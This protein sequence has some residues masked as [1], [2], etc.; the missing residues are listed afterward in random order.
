MQSRK[1]CSAL[2][3]KETLTHA[4]T[5]MNFED[6]MLREISQSQK[7]KYCWFHLHQVHRVIIFIKTESG[8]VVARSG[9]EGREMESLLTKFGVLIEEIEINSGGEWW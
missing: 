6:I 1:Y 7:D 3:R 8:I 5:W 9:G 4:T 2:K